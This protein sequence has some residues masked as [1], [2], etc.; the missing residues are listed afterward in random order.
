M[1]GLE[2]EFFCFHGDIQC[3]VNRKPPRRKI[4]QR[5]NE[6][7]ASRPLDDRSRATEGLFL[8]PQFFAPPPQTKTN[9]SY[10][11]SP[12]LQGLSTFN[13]LGFLQLSLHLM[14]SNKPVKCI[15]F[16]TE[17]FC[18]FILFIAVHFLKASFCQPCLLNV[19]SCN[20]GGNRFDEE[21]LDNQTLKTQ[22][23]Q[24][25]KH[26][27]IAAN[28]TSQR[29]T[30]SVKTPCSSE[31]KS[32]KNQA[33]KADNVRDKSS[34]RA[35]ASNSTRT[36][37]GAFSPFDLS[38]SDEAMEATFQAQE[39]GKAS[40]HGGKS[41]QHLRNLRELNKAE[42]N[43]TCE[44]EA[45]GT[46]GHELESNDD[47]ADAGLFPGSANHKN[48]EHPEVN[49]ET[50]R[51]NYNSSSVRDNLGKRK[52][53]ER[54]EKG[55]SVRNSNNKNNSLPS[56]PVVDNNT[57]RSKR[58][59]K[60]KTQGHS[61]SRISLDHH[62]SEE[63]KR[64]E[65]MTRNQLRAELKV[66]GLSVAGN[67]IDLFNRLVAWVKTNVSK[68]EPEEME[69]VNETNEDNEDEAVIRQEDEAHLDEQMI[70]GLQQEGEVKKV[71]GEQEPP[72]E[73]TEAEELDSEENTK[74]NSS[75]DNIQPTSIESSTPLTPVTN[76]SPINSAPD[77][78]PKNTP[79]SC[80]PNTSSVLTSTLLAPMSFPPLPEVNQPSTAIPTSKSKSSSFSPHSPFSPSLD[81]ANK[82]TTF[83]STLLSN[84]LTSTA[85]MSTSTVQLSAD[86]AFV[87]ES[88]PSPSVLTS[89]TCAPCSSTS[90]DVSNYD[91][92]KE[93]TETNRTVASEEIE[94]TP[95][96][97][98]KGRM[99]VMR[100][101]PRISKDNLNCLEEMDTA[102]VVIPLDDRIVQTRRSYSVS[103]THDKIGVME[104]RGETI[105][106]NE[107]RNSQSNIDTINDLI[108]P[109]KTIIGK[110][111]TR[112]DDKVSPYAPSLIQS[113]F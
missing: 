107:K 100:S 74:G 57:E 24:T 94:L 38:L 106:Q 56:R 82:C 75:T 25:H 28:G 79:S 33:E 2:E 47:N 83:N 19:S 108:S 6:N 86:P 101:P 77:H 27:G 20:C 45:N 9:N 72:T 39:R 18:C 29:E 89:S 62:A 109:T 21:D 84:S 112:C 91:P 66:K 76:T 34:A 7:S 73:R 49:Q 65:A 22:K 23:R 26:K 87:F 31:K 111:D 113:Q 37:F 5:M 1:A 85:A 64:L 35:L 11:Q 78:S 81:P 98:D 10:W 58:P 41:L 46:D 93:P 52:R 36:A 42:P 69:T 97:Q 61:F 50:G 51:D 95:S 17:I 92:Q 14:T 102:S 43:N 53:S 103:K 44:N 60:Q 63:I 48:V 30:S 99:H 90:L 3:W 88:C 96:N 13:S 104:G 68:E 110:Q 12:Q 4:L 32:T 70:E 16:A 67:K 80:E 15:Q 59:K 105:S 54:Q 8:Y 40:G 71:P 55:F